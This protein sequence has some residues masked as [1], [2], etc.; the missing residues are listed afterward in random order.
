MDLGIRGGF[1]NQPPLNTEGRLY[2][3]LCIC[4]FVGGRLGGFHFFGYCE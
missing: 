3:I 4:S 1:W 2:H